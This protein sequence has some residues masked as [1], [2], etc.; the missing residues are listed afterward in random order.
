MPQENKIQ[1]WIES[2]LGGIG[3]AHEDRPTFNNF[4]TLIAMVSAGM[5]TAIVP[6]YAIAACR[7]YGVRA[8]TLVEPAACLSFYRI[9]KR[10][11]AA[12]S[13]MDEFIKAFVAAVPN[14]P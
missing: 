7:R 2:H 1:Q 14:M 4:E 6:S 10:G 9:T 11:R 12:A 5:G 13:L 8:V 3:R